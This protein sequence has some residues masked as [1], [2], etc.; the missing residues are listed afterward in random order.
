MISGCEIEN[1]LSWLKSPRT[2]KNG[3][4]DDFQKLSI[5]IL[6][7]VGLFQLCCKLSGVFWAFFNT[8]GTFLI[9]TVTTA[10]VFG[11]VGPFFP[12]VNSLLA[13]YQLK[14]QAWGWKLIQKIIWSKFPAGTFLF[15]GRKVYGDV[16]NNEMFRLLFRTP[17]FESV[18][19]PVVTPQLLIWFHSGSR[20]RICAVNLCGISPWSNPPALSV[21]CSGA[22]GGP[23]V[24]NPSQVSTVASRIWQALTLPYFI[25]TAAKL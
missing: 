16:L 4:F 8:L 9:F 18:T 5:L 22:A 7:F 14:Q 20:V 17:V 15:S 10:T 25:I 21:T 19:W 24:P 3:N 11:S 2:S 6:C 12:V 13:S 1:Q 23:S